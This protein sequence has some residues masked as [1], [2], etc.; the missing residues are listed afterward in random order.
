MLVFNV[1]QTDIPTVT[2][3]LAVGMPERDA[4][5]V[6]KHLGSS[7][8]SNLSL[9]GLHSSGSPCQTTQGGLRR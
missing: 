9:A 7:F 2:P 4:L 5:I 1:K 8:P 3:Q 6:P